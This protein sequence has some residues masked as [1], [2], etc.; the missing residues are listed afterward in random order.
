MYR[1]WMCKEHGRQLH[2]YT[3][4][5]CRQAMQAVYVPIFHTESVKK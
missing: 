2:A 5:H 3:C 1:K 4:P